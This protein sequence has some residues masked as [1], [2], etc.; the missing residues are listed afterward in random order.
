MWVLHAVSP[1]LPHT[2]NNN[3]V[4]APGITS[5]IMETHTHTHTHTHTPHT[6]HT[7]HT[8]HTHTH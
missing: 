4:E 5:R 6:T 3:N 8:T 2:A 7:T 1:P